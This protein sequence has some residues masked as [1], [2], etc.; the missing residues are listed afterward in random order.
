VPQAQRVPG[1]MQRDA[2]DID[3]RAYF[4]S[5]VIIKM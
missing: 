1:L 3:I 4:P 5:F 2:E